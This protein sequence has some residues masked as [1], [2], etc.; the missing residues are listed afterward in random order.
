MDAEIK[1]EFERSGFFFQEEEEQILQKCQ[2]VHQLQSQPFGSGLQLGDLLSQQV[3]VF[4]TAEY[5]TPK[6][7]L[8]QVVL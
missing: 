4:M 7:S 1:A 2:H 5:Q 6:N 3:F 8:N